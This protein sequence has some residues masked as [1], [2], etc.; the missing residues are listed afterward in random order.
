[1][2]FKCK[3]CGGSLKIEKGQKIVTCA[4]CGV[5]Q[6][7][8]KNENDKISN[9]YDR[10][11]HFLRNNEYDKAEAIYETILSED[12][13]DS[14]AYW[15][16]V[17]CKYGV[18]YVKD[19][20][21]GK[22]IPT[23]NRTKTT[24]IFAD[25]DYKKAL[26]NATKEQ[27]E[28][29]EK[30]AKEI[31]EIQKRILELSNKEEKYDVFICYKEKD[32]DGERTQ[33]SV[34]AQEI[35]SKLIAEGLRVFFAR[36]TL[37]DKIGIEYEPYIFAALN[38]SKVMIVIGTNK[39]YFEAP[40]VR[41]EWSRYLSLI[42]QDTK[43]TLI[44]CF[45]DIDAYDLP[46]EFAHLQAQDMSKIGF[47]QDLVRGVKK[48]TQEEQKQNNINLV[49]ELSDSQKEHIYKTS[50][51]DMQITQD[52]KVLSHREKTK[53]FR[54]LTKN[55]EK[56]GEYLDSE[57]LA[58]KCNELYKKEKH[59]KVVGNIKF[60]SIFLIV[61]LIIISVLMTTYIVPNSKY[62]IAL[63]K[64]NNNQY[65]SA[66][67][68]FSK[69][70]DYKNSKEIIK[71][72]KE[73]W[74]KANINT[75]CSAYGKQIAA[76]KE[77]GTVLGYGSDFLNIKQAVYGDNCIVG[78]RNDG[79]IIIET[80]TTDDTI[81]GLTKDWEDIESIAISNNHI[82]GLKNNGTVLSEIYK[83][84]EY[85]E[86]K[87]IDTSDWKQIVQIEACLGGIVGL[88]E[89]GT[90]VQ[91]EVSTDT[92]LK[93]GQW[94]DIIQ[95]SGTRGFLIGLKEDGTMVATGSNGY[96]EINVENETD[97]IQL[98][99]NYYSADHFAFIKSDGTVKA[100]GE[101]DS[102]QCDITDWSNIVYLYAG[103]T[104][105]IGVKKDGRISIA[106]TYEESDIGL[107]PRNWSN[108]KRFEEWRSMK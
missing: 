26:E 56:L 47:M 94:K 67:K 17:L 29:Y 16:L 86:V 70:E 49:N 24:A 96:G 19:P 52:A 76:V 89:D 68:D 103:S 33:D 77:I 22:Y 53:I 42:K 38:S 95:L 48:L 27:R 6:T 21:T 5:Q 23:C 40:W 65:Y 66:I 58:Q 84:D 60:L 100:L 75:V 11:N 98:S 81:Q 45:K 87:E 10:A 37:E 106:G 107:Q 102:K 69:I 78:L 90:V 92:I 20:A 104:N 57:Q 88:R 50:K 46:E 71:N 13:E 79:T 61:S 85:S 4:Y 64:Y 93:I 55:F 15:S 9:L 8:P 25:E 43:K 35:Y 63:E 91:K 30:Q 34:L 39:E 80:N 7:L 44:P 62:E 59:K 108:I 1:M 105:T 97:V 28:I 32:K 12:I 82:F 54:D 41:N 72:A 51:K 31:N 99:R 74:K 2:V 14:E 83:K 18:E 3:I 73:K 36:I 101:N